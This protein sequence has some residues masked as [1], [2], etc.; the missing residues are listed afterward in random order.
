MQDYET[1][2][3]KARERLKALEMELVDPSVYSDRRESARKNRAYARQKDLVEALQALAGKIRERQEAERL[4]EDPLE[5]EDVRD[6]ARGELE[7]LDLE[8]PRM[9]NQAKR[10]L[11]PPDEDANRGVIL[12]IRAGTGG[13]EAALFAAEL[14]R[15]L[16]RHAESRSWKTSLI[17]SHPTGSGGMKEIIASMEGEGVFGRLRY[18]SGVHRVQRVPLTESA[19]RIHTSAVTVAVLPSAE[20]V[21]VEI[22]Q[23]DIRVDRFRSSGPGGQSVN[24]TDSAIRITHIPTG[25]V[26]SCQDE[27]SQ[28]KNLAKAMKV[29]RSRL[30]QRE[31][32]RQEQERSDQRRM[33]VG[34]GDRSEKIRTYNF[35]QNRVTDH[36]IG[37]TLY[38]LDRFMEGEMDEM[39]D[40][41]IEEDEAKRLHELFD[42]SGSS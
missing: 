35:P 41:L 42:P 34:S 23:E 27:K 11:L 19:G 10:L 37:F 8:I 2:L 28:H 3:D 30:L 4:C 5:D 22:D 39:L 7:S 17:D 1:W 16:Q 25:E 33:M 32:E 40:A 18:E 6:L 14:F 26:V 36:R 13:E 15:M 9:E 31:R 29:L 38:S 21:D 20:E 24:T 12:E